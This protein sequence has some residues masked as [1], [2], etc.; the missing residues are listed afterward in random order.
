MIMKNTPPQTWS[1]W[2]S[3]IVL[4]HFEDVETMQ[5]SGMLWEFAPLHIPRFPSRSTWR[6]STSTGT[7][8]TKSTTRARVG[9]STIT[10]RNVREGAD[11]SKS[12]L[13]YAPFV[14]DND[15]SHILNELIS[16]FL[17]RK[18]FLFC[19]KNSFKTKSRICIALAE[20]NCVF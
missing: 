1:Q 17:Q 18:F 4:L 5:K 2:C 3:S 8:I 16:N 14:T 20:K 6:T 12:L 7:S 19:I 10:R 13:D 9:T 15:F 11:V